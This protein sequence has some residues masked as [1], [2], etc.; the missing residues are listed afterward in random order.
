[1]DPCQAEL[2]ILGRTIRARELINHVSRRPLPESG[3]VFIG[4]FPG[5]QE[6]NQVF[7][8]IYLLWHLI[9]ERERKTSEKFPG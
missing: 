6:A 7:L 2:T 1:M 4:G 9:R 5:L 8:L 3:S